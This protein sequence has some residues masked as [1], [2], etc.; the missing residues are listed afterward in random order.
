MISRESTVVIKL[1][2]FYLVMTRSDLISLSQANSHGSPSDY[3][4][5]P[6]PDQFPD[7]LAL[8]VYA[9]NA[10]IK[11]LIVEFF[12]YLILNGPIGL[13]RSRINLYIYSVGINFLIVI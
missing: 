6:P 13:K 4:A 5:P 8:I 9:N 10:A 12:R 7:L 11:K 3:P 2:W 1:P